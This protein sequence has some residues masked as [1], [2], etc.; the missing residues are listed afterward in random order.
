MEELKQQFGPGGE[1]L[2]VSDVIDQQGRQYV[3][4]VQEGGGVLGIALVGF[5]YVLEQMG[6]RF[7][8]LAG[9]SAG[10]INTI[11]LAAIGQKGEAKSEQI[12]EYLAQTNLLSF[13]DGHGVVPWVLKRLLRNKNFLKHLLYGMLALV[14]VLMVSMFIGAMYPH[15]TWVWFILITLGLTLITVL[16]LRYLWGRFKRRNWGICRGQ[17]FHAWITRILQEQGIQTVKQL[18]ER[19]YNT[20]ADNQLQLKQDGM[21]L[22]SADDAR[23]DSLQSD[24]TMIACDITTQM[25]VEFPRMAMLYGK[26]ANT[27]PADFVR[28]SMSIPVFFESYGMGPI[29]THN[30]DVR[31]AWRSINIPAEK[32][33]SYVNFVDGGV[34]SNFPI[35][36][37]HNP[38]IKVPRLPVIGVRLADGDD[39][40]AADVFSGLASYIGA[41][42]NTVRFNYDKEFLSK[43]NF[44]T[45]YVASID[46]RDF[47]WLNFAMPEE[48]QKRL[49]LQGVQTAADYLRAFNWED[50]K[51]GRMRLYEQLNPAVSER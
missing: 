27:N 9:T 15:K 44:Y 18:M 49:F 28:A 2:K 31:A 7:W 14:S 40:T 41:V 30:P 8:R 45:Q 36:V 5:T 39:D 32:I 20:A 46:V 19:A 3:N 16:Y 24:V 25:K 17:A 6:I 13:V 12:L 4:L 34:I 21:K 10:A 50:Y 29:D 26:D 22:R 23:V 38:A 35:N 43:N 48:E 47:N 1:Q 37:F 33:P 11:C 42:F 51:Q